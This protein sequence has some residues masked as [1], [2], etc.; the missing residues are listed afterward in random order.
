MAF[1]GMTCREAGKRGGQ[2]SGV[3]RLKKG[4]EMLAK[5]ATFGELLRVVQELE[6]RAYQKGWHAGR[7]SRK[8]A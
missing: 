6:H 2:A 1:G 3:V 8:V 4:R 5:C 7:R